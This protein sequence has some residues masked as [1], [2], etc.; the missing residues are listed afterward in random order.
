[1][2]PT[3]SNRPEWTVLFLIGLG[4]FLTACAPRAV[5]RPTLSEARLGQSPHLVGD[6]TLHPGESRAEVVAI[7]PVRQEIR[8]RTDDGRRQ[9]VALT[10]DPM[11]TRVVYHGRDYRVEDLEAG[12]LIAFETR[13]PRSRQVEIIRLQEPV[14]ARAGGAIVAQRPLPRPQVIEGTVEK[15]DLDLGVFEIRPRDGRPVTVSIPYNARSSDVESFRRL[16]R[17]DLVRLEGEFVNPESFQL[18]AF[19]PEFDRFQSRR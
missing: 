9:P 10:Y 8:A 3:K 6:T 12:D 14:Q 18:L 16:R 5:V 15:V 1:M 11:T 4:A 17:G 19:L 2:K 7:D 13:S